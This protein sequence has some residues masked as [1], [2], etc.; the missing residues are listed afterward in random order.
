METFVIQPAEVVAAMSL[1]ERSRYQ[2]EHHVWAILR[3]G[4]L[5]T[6]LAEAG[7]KIEKLEEAHDFD[8]VG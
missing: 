8:M 1:A 4:E 3:I 6:E 5:E 2:H 7:K